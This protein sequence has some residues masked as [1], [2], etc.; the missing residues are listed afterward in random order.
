[1]LALTLH[2]PWAWAFTDAGKR[3]ENRD[4]LPGHQLSRG[5]FVA[6]CAGKTYDVDGAAQLREMLDEEE[7]TVPDEKD[8]V[9]GA[10]AAV[11]RFHS[12]RRR[13]PAKIH[14]DRWRSDAEYGW[15][16]DEVWKLPTRVPCRGRQRLWRLPPDVQEEVDHQWGKCEA[17]GT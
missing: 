6:L 9:M 5:D 7:L 2:E 14:Q 10:V 13:I 16:Y 4:W 11:A 17:V 15:Y 12:A 8:L 3:I 1:M